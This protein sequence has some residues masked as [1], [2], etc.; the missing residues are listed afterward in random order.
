MNIEIKKLTPEL[1]D[2]YL[3]FFENVAHTDNE[4][5][6]RCYCTNFC[7]ARNNHISQKK[8]FRNPDIRKQYAIKYVND[9][10]LQGYL[11]YADGNVIGWCNANERNACLH[12][13]GWKNLIGNKLINKKTNE[14]VKS[15]FCFAVA[16]DM[17]GKGVA[18]ALL[19]R[20]IEDAEIEGYE[21]VEAYPNKEEPDIFYNYVG[22]LPM[23]IK[24]GFEMYAKTKQRF[25]F[26][27][28]LKSCS[29]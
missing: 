23:Y 13:F 3:Y 12:C 1:L 27:K 25:V 8:S 15:V 19:N 5:W 16:P 7:A 28:R 24:L 20:V 10:L 6:D 29:K 26:R 22:P 4:E 17:R 18:S 11:A 9:G 14:R 21:Y 2:D